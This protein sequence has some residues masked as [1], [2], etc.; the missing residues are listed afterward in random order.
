MFG[1]KYLHGPWS[2]IDDSS[3][4]DDYENRIAEKYTKLKLRQKDMNEEQVQSMSMRQLML[5]IHDENLTNFKEIGKDHKELM[6][7]HKA[8]SVKGAN[9]V[10]TVRANRKETRLHDF[11]M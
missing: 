11:E 5:D 4:F 1:N 3:M 10:V 7:A 9:D 2:C 6:L 8:T